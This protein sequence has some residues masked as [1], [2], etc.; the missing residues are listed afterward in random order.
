M[1]LTLEGT[2]KKFDIK[3]NNTEI[4]SSVNKVNTNINKKGELED[5]LYKSVTTIVKP[6]MSSPLKETIETAKLNNEFEANK[7]VMK[8]N[9]LENRRTQNNYNLFRAIHPNDRQNHTKGLNPNDV[10]FFSTTH[11]RSQMNK[12]NQK[13]YSHMISETRNSMSESV[14]NCKS[15]LTFN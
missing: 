14:P 15:Y 2:D 11:E 13:D 3:A 6:W 12:Y 10:Q 4:N 9:S 7:Q 8:E 1:P 5:V